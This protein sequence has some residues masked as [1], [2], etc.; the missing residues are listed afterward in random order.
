MGHEP[1]DHFQIQSSSGQDSIVTCF[2]AVPFEY[3]SFGEWGDGKQGTFHYTAFHSSDHCLMYT[4][5]SRCSK[6]GPHGKNDEVSIIKR[7][8]YKQVKLNLFITKVSL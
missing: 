6:L 1:T 3:S 7:N 8:G 5:H 2:S 4:V